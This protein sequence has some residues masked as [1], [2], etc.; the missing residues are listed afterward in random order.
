MGQGLTV[1]CKSCGAGGNYTLGVGMMYFPLENVLDSVVPKRQREKVRQ[2]LKIAGQDAAQ[3]SHTLYACPK[4]GAL[5]GRFYIKVARGKETLFETKF[6]CGKCKHALVAVPN[7]D[8][9]GYPCPACGKRTLESY[10]TLS[11]D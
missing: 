10:I 11:W 4:C 1:K 7:D 6:R 8:V 5:Q 2:A 3:Y 9:S